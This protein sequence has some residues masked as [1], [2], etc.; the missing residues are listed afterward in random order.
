MR[1]WI[2]KAPT[3]VS[4]CVCHC[5]GGCVH[6]RQKRDALLPTQTSVRLKVSLVCR[7]NSYLSCD[8]PQMAAWRD[9]RQRTDG[10]F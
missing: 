10:G 6:A 3:H 2:H 7:V 1:F 9:H 4:V 8:S 5:V